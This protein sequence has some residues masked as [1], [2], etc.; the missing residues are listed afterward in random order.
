MED[1]KTFREVHSLLP[2][3]QSFYLPM[4][5]FIKHDIEIVNDFYVVHIRVLKEQLGLLG[6]TLL[7]P[8]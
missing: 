1:D 6:L 4:E 8:L 3:K 7:L 2:P 5:C